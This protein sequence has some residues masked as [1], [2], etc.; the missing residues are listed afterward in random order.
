MPCFV[1]EEHRGLRWHIIRPKV[2]YLTP[3]S[4]SYFEIAEWVNDEANGPTERGHWVRWGKTGDFPSLCQAEY[5]APFP[6]QEMLTVASS[7]ASKAL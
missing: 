3:D 1:P 2:P 7:E 6:D 4:M 5:L